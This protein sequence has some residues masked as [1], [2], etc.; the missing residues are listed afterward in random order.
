MDFFDKFVFNSVKSDYEIKFC[1]PNK[2]VFKIELLPL[3]RNPKE[4]SGGSSIVSSE[5]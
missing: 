1:Q 4:G 5:V 2:V 3:Q